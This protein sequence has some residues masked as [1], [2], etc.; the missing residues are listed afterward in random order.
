MTLTPEQ[1]IK[2]IA[3]RDLVIAELRHQITKLTAEILL[4]REP[5]GFM[6]VQYLKDS[7]YKSYSREYAANVLLSSNGL[8]LTHV[9][10]VLRQFALLADEGPLTVQFFLASIREMQTRHNAFIRDLMSGKLDNID[11]D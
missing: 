10:Y 4:Q 3:D 7:G 8:P 5:R 2:S 9:E 1:Y 6:D 11:E